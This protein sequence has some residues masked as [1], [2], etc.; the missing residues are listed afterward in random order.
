MPIEKMPHRPPKYIKDKINSNE[1]VLDVW[2]SISDI[3]KNEWIC[4]I[5]S[6]KKDETKQGRIER[7]L[8]DLQNG[9]KRPCCWSGC[10]HRVKAN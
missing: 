10:P 4:F 5:D 6:A 3:A 2:N 9:K 1:V 8:N 7:L